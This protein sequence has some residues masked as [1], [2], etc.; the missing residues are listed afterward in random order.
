V[1][2]TRT[3]FSPAASPRV[4]PLVLGLVLALLVLV[5]LG[6]GAGPADGSTGATGAVRVADSRGNGGLTTLRM[7]HRPGGDRSSLRS[8][9]P[10]E[11]HGVLRFGR[12]LV[13]RHGAWSRRP[14]RFR[15]QWL[16]AGRPIPGATA[17]RHVAEVAQGDGVVDLEGLAFRAGWGPGRA[18]SAQTGRVRHRGPVRHVVTYHVE[19]R[20]RVVADLAVFRRQLQATYD[21]PRGWRGTG[22]RLRRV[23]H[24]GDLTVVLAEADAVPRFSA[25][26]SA[27]WSCRVG[28]YVVV[29][30]ARWVHGTVAWREAGGRLRDYRSMVINHETGHWLGQGHRTCPR[31]GAPAPVMQQQSKGLDGCRGNAWPTA[32]ERTLPRWW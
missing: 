27:R 2:R 24:G 10:P 13:A 12:T 16:R 30:Q 32:A 11:V 19:T 20:G 15:Y 23:R 21:D 28:R 26:C 7:L 25:G 22:V 29:N 31:P 9:R 18:R 14:D 3:A 17:R 6:A 8:R 1:T 4:V 5:L